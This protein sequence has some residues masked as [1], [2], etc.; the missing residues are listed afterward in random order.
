ML[1]I[2]EFSALTGISIHMLRN[3]DKIG[4]LK[5]EQVDSMNSYRFYDEKQIVRAN[6]IQV[7]KRLGF[8]LNEISEILT[9]NTL[10]D[11]IKDFLKLKIKEKEE[12]LSI[13]ERQ[14]AQLR[15]A[16]NELDTRNDC[17]LSVVVKS[18]APR[19]FVSLRDVIQEFN[20]EGLL[21]ERLD[22]ACRV[23]GVRVS[24]VQYCME[25]THSMDFDNK[26]IDTEVF[27]VVEQVGPDIEGLRFSEI[28]E[29]EAAVVAFRGNYSR[30]SDINRYIYHW[31]VENG[32]RIA[33]K[34]FNIYYVSPENETDPENFVTEICYP[35][36]KCS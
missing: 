22:R 15:Q 12:S 25:V 24:D 10:D 13:T 21:W 4:L 1:K 3:Y 31:I 8:G 29:T 5:P 11:R 14:I 17:T 9:D 32:Y 6:Y 33:G 27:R 26:R 18:F 30:I 16:L 20:E 28:P 35:I 34:V 2:G 36:K 19:C 23:N 7:L